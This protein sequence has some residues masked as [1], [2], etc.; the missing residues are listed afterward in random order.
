VKK[1][2]QNPSE[3]FCLLGGLGRNLQQGLSM[4]N[5]IHI[6]SL[7]ISANGWNALA[8]GLVATKQLATF[9]MNL[10]EVDRDGLLAFA[11]GMK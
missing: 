2:S 1:I 9:K 8:K 11:E 7:H 6:V 10:C 4:L 3:T 5:H